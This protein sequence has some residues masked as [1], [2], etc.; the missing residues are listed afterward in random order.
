M[1]GPAEGPGE[2]CDFTKAC[3]RHKMQYFALNGTPVHRSPFT[4]CPMTG[5]RRSHCRPAAPTPVDLSHTLVEPATRP[6]AVI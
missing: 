4:R 5:R 6:Q 1:V 3:A 2:S